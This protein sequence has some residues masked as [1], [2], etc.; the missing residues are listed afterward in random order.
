MKAA[1]CPVISARAGTP[2][3][4]RVREFLQDKHRAA[5][6]RHVAAGGTAERQVGAGR[7][8]DSE[9]NPDWIWETR[10]YGLIGASVPPHSW[11][12]WPRRIALPAERDRVQTARRTPS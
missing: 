1:V 9:S 7:V 11:T 12:G 6:G 2:R 4:L 8:A 5:L 3:S 10:A